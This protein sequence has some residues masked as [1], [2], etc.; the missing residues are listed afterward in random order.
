MEDIE[1]NCLMSNN[2]NSY[3]KDSEIKD[4]SSFKGKKTPVNNILERLFKKGLNLTSLG[5][6][7][8]KDQSEN[9]KDNG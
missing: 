4:N 2:V 3:C 7:E 9:K 5:S 6:F 8:S 1:T